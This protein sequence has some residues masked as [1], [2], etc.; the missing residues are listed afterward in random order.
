[1]SLEE[2]GRGGANAFRCETAN[3]LFIF[4]LHDK[5]VLVF[6]VLRLLKQWT[7]QADVLEFEDKLTTHAPASLP[8]STVPTDSR[9]AGCDMTHPGVPAGQRQGVTRAFCLSDY[10]ASWGKNHSEETESG[11]QGP[12]AGTKHHGSC[13]RDRKCVVLTSVKQSMMWQE[14]AFYGAGK[15]Q[16]ISTMAWKAHQTSSPGEVSTYAETE[17]TMPHQDLGKKPDCRLHLQTVSQIWPFP[18]CLPPSPW[19]KLLSSGSPQ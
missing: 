4:L 17:T 15:Q 2:E 6:K 11:S 8:W 3:L 5:P 14:A 10:G 9:G 13:Q 18:A 1:M 19:S 7:S 12:Q 16:V